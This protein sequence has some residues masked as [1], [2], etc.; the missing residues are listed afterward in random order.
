MIPSF[1]F[2]SIN[3][4]NEVNLFKQYKQQLKK[5][6]NIA[7]KRDKSSRSA[8]AS[9]TGSASD[10][11]A[12]SASGSVQATPAKSRPSADNIPCESPLH[13]SHGSMTLPHGSPATPATPAR[14]PNH[15]RRPR[16]TPDEINAKWKEIFSAMER[17]T[18][19]SSSYEAAAAAQT[20]YELDLTK[21]DRMMEGHSI[22]AEQ[23]AR[24]VQLSLTQQATGIKKGERKVIVPALPA[25]PAA[26]IPP[27]LTPFSP[28]VASVD[29]EWRASLAAD[30]DRLRGDALDHR[31]LE[32]RLMEYLHRENHPLTHVKE[33]FVANF[34]EAYSVL[35]NPTLK[36]C[37]TNHAS[38]LLLSNTLPTLLYFLDLLSKLLI[39][40]FP[41]LDAVR[42]PN[43]MESIRQSSMESIFPSIFPTLFALYKRKYFFRDAELSSKMSVLS[44]TGHGGCNITLEDMGVSKWFCLDERIVEEERQK[45]L[46]KK[47][48][49]EREKR[50][51]A[52][53]TEEQAT[54]REAEEDR[55]RDTAAA[56]VSTSP[57]Q[58]PLASEK[59]TVASLASPPTI[60]RANPA[61]TLQLS[62]PQQAAGSL[63]GPADGSI[64]PHPISQL[65]RDAD[66][67]AES[68]SSAVPSRH[69]SPSPPPSNGVPSHSRPRSTP[70]TPHKSPG[71]R[72]TLVAQ[73]P[74]RIIPTTR[75]TPVTDF[76]AGSLGRSPRAEKIQD[77]LSRSPSRRI[78]SALPLPSPSALSKSHTRSAHIIDSSP[79]KAKS[80]SQ[81]QVAQAEVA[82]NGNGAAD[83]SVSP[84][85][86]GVEP[87]LSIA[88][89][90]LFDSSSDPSLVRTPSPAHDAKKQVGFTATFS[91]AAD[92]T[93]ILGPTPSPAA[94]THQGAS[95]MAT[96]A[97]GSSSLGLALK[98]LRHSPSTDQNGHA[99]ASALTTPP[100]AIDKPRLG[101]GARTIGNV[102]SSTISDSDDD[103]SSSS[104]SP[105][106]PTM[107]GMPAMGSSMPM[108]QGLPSSMLT[109]TPG[110]GAE[111]LKQEMRQKKET[112][113]SNGTDA[114]D[115]AAATQHLDSQQPFVLNSSSA[116]APSA[117]DPDTDADLEPAFPY[118][119]AVVLLRRLTAERTPRDKLQCLIAVSQEVCW[120]VDRFYSRECFTKTNF[121]PRPEELCINADD[122]LS[123]VS[124]ILIK[125]Q[126][127]NAISE[128]AFIDDFISR[129]M[130]IHLPGYFLS[131]LQASIELITKLDKQKFLTREMVE[132][133]SDNGAANGGTAVPTAT[134]RPSYLGSNANMNGALS[135]SLPRVHS[136]PIDAHAS[137]NGVSNHASHGVAGSQPR[138]G[139]GIRHPQPLTL[140]AGQQLQRTTPSSRAP[141][142]PPAGAQPLESTQRPTRAAVGVPPPAIGSSRHTST[143][144]V[145]SDSSSHQRSI[146]FHSSPGSRLE[147]AEP[148]ATASTSWSQPFELKMEHFTPTKPTPPL[149]PVRKLA[150][151]AMGQTRGV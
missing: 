146:S 104:S 139:V 9:A 8:Y 58:N 45:S 113:R 72:S 12:T 95:A 74:V 38:D 26:P 149:T 112:K 145:S 24:L 118:Q 73:S 48:R 40:I 120:C 77:M 99:P 37:T 78:A 111:L 70:T 7:A 151:A 133:W 55:Q 1:H 75:L 3:N 29:L 42:N 32:S 114:N 49:K 52:G 11:T 20:T 97:N 57:Q 100:R 138:V 41:E 2:A 135:S 103:D 122:L 23:Y 148:E 85:T 134:R 108:L 51:A 83:T 141:A 44:S 10:S 143:S 50:R 47:R 6:E 106:M 14:T 18:A 125:S 22:Q 16:M 54:I 76:E 90:M 68:T 130:K 91:T 121:R 63:D 119:E 126:L 101:F 124:F 31:M 142:G 80:F 89:G 25:P 60:H 30:P 33:Q 115:T 39:K 62:P 102:S 67:A 35:K 137:P 105:R 43:T 46:E 64:L 123:I 117:D 150:Q 61:H 82:L 27:P 87:S 93:P 96:P 59:K 53:E 110:T 21:Y 28:S 5:K 92:S 13:P 140:T 88:S 56:A 132:Q 71:Y 4:A 136:K 98:Q 128:A 107:D 131:T 17:W 144:S 147:G 116:A 66:D 127:A 129:P 36:G 34:L 79:V 15:V 69:Q 86:N 84:S 19:E 109:H 94:S 65:T 81:A